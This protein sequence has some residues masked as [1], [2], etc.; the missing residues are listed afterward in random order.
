MLTLIITLP[1]IALSFLMVWLWQKR[2]IISMI[3]ASLLAYLAMVVPGMIQTFQAMMIY[4]SGDPQL[5]AG[6]ISQAMTGSMLAMF[7]ILPLLILFQW[8]GRTRRRA[9]QKRADS[10][11]EFK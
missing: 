7:V 10:L 11:D 6:G 8:I 1:I 2:P 4:G 9:K 3:L 5:M